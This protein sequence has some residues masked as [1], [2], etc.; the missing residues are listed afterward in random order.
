LRLLGWGF[1]GINNYMSILNTVLS[2]FFLH[3]AVH[4][5]LNIKRNTIIAVL[6]G[7]LATLSFGNGILVWP[8]GLLSLYL[9]RAPLRFSRVFCAGCAGVFCA[10]SIVAWRQRS[11]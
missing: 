8:I 11:K 7:G 2:I 10:V 5:S 3:R 1:N 6:L 4:Q 9:W